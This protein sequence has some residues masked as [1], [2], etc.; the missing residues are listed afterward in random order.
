MKI[1]EWRNLFVVERKFDQI[2]GQSDKSISYTFRI[3]YVFTFPLRKKIPIKAPYII[4]HY[5]LIRT[6]DQSL[7]VYVLIW[8]LLLLFQ[9]YI[10]F[11]VRD[12][13]CSCMS[14]C[15]PKLETPLDL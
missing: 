15:L 12:C 3:N 1:S 7:W 8:L 14:R 6:D 13:M 11:K 4:F 2:H 10:Y 5:Y 9:I